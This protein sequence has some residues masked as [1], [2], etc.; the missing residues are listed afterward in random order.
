MQ[1]LPDPSA[2]AF[3][4]T[5]FIVLLSKS[6]SPQFVYLLSR[7][8]EFRENA[9]KSMT[10]ASGR[11]R[12]QEACFKKFMIPVPPDELIKRFSKAVGPMF[13]L[14]H[15]LHLAGK[16][17]RETRDLLLPQLLS[18]NVTP[19]TVAPRIYEQPPS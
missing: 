10:G 14:I 8:R 7:S 6:L 19:P 2:V 16:N 9:I 4:S 11:Q 1:F 5:E 18:G 12:V 3:G 13:R 17:L 15:N